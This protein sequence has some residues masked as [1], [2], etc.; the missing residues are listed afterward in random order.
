M[1]MKPPLRV[2]NTDVLRIPKFYEA[3]HR[4]QQIKHL[5]W[6]AAKM[7]LQIIEAPCYRHLSLET[8]RLP[9][10]TLNR[11]C[12]TFELARDPYRP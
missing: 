2:L 4:T 12:L 1:F 3:Q 11:A 5:K 7:G 9:T 8:R 10:S 6:R